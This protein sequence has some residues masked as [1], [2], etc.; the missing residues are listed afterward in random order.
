MRPL[1]LVIVCLAAL[2]NEA[3]AYSGDGARG[4]ALA[5][6]HCARCHVIGDFNKYGGLGSTP[7]FPRLVKLPDWRD[8]F[9]TFFAR[10]PHPVF[11]RM[12]GLESTSLSPSHVT[13][14]DF[15]LDDLTDLLTYVESQ[16]EA[17]KKKTDD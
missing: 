8:R 6:Q 13:P 9:E 12:P 1:F 4:R 3:V 10:R 16:A 17:A 14:F 15:D 11:V 7:S 2:Q 5:E